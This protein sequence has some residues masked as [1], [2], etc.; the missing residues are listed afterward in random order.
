MQSEEYTLS[1][2][3]LRPNF[4]I[5]HKLVLNASVN[6]L[7]DFYLMLDNPIRMPCNSLIDLLLE[8]SLYYDLSHNDEFLTGWEEVEKDN[9]VVI[10]EKNDD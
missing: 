8:C 4:H 9:V 3:D 10:K 6:T 7:S 1:L 2:E 5:D